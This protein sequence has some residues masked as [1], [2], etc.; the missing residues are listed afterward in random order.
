MAILLVDAEASDLQVAPATW[1]DVPG[2]TGTVTPQGTGSVLILMAHVSLDDLSSSDKTAEF[3]FTVAGSSTGSPIGYAFKDQIAEANDLHLFWAVD[4]QS[5]STAFALQWQIVQST[6]ASSGVRVRQFQILELDAGAALLVDTSAVSTDADPAS[7]TNV[8]SLSATVTPKSGSMLLF[9]M[10]GFVPAV[11]A[12]AQ[13]EFRFALGTTPARDGPQVLNMSNSNATGDQVGAA[14]IW[15][16]TGHAASSQ[17]L[18]LQWQAKFGNST[19]A[20][21]NRIFQVVE[22]DADFAIGIDVLVSTQEVVSVTDWD[23]VPSM[24]GAL[25]ADS[26]DSVLLMLAA[27]VFNVGDSTDDGALLRFADD[28]TREGAETQAFKDN[29]SSWGPWGLSNAKVPANTSSHT[30][31]LR[32]KRQSGIAETYAAP[33]GFQVIDFKAAAAGQI[34][35]VGTLAEVNALIATLPIKVAPIGVLAEIETLIPAGAV[36]VAPIGVLGESNSLIPADPFKTAAI[37]TLAEAD[38]LLPIPAVKPI[39]TGVGTLPEVNALNTISP[40]KGATIGT[41]AEIDAL[42]AVLARKTADVGTLAEID[43]LIPVA[44]EQPGEQVIDVGVL[45]ETNP[46]IAIQARK[47][48][49]IGVLA[50]INALIAVQAR[51]I[52]AIGTL[53]EN[54]ALIAVLAEKRATIGTLSEVD[55]FIPVSPVK[56]AVIGQVSEID[57]LIAIQARKFAS[58][59]TLPEVDALIPIAVQVGNSVSVGVL[60]E[61]DSLLAIAAFKTASIGTIAETDVLRPILPRKVAPIGTIGEV[62]S[63]IAVQALKLAQIGVLAEINALI[64]IAAIKPITVDIGTIAEINALISVLFTIGLERHFRRTTIAQQGLESS[65]AQVSRVV[66]VSQSGHIVTIDKG[67]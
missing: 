16:E 15:A 11:T 49:V 50:E 54:D 10:S 41:L 34:I 53:A 3:R 1:A 40:V 9:I 30:Y 38:S 22:V 26:T 21:L 45:A 35:A 48:A 8:P 2:M 64:A 63:L 29:A 56:V 46:L 55:S 65:M 43:A 37:G 28:G 14:M 24:T 4:G 59:G 47:I 19:L 36:K 18:S 6:P 39:V 57:S 33:R 66:V 61:F 17:T 5:G 51:K 7:W 20:A 58:I 44:V 27:G 52:A 31:T 23:V 60:A 42:I 62:D 25:S 12:A 13:S 32:G 67:T